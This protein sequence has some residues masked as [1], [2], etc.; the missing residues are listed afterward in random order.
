MNLLTLILFLLLTTLTQTLTPPENT[1]LPLHPLHP[2]LRRT[3][4]PELDIPSP[5]TPNTPD[6]DDTLWHRAHCRGTL[7]LHAMPLSESA[8]STLLSWPYTQSPFDGDLKRELRT[9]GYTDDDALHEQSDAYCDFE[10]WHHVGRAFGEL[11]VDT[12]SKGMGGPNWCW[13]LKHEGGPSVVR[14]EGGELPEVREQRYMVGGREYKITNAYSRIAIN[15]PSGILFFLHRKSPEHAAAELWSDLPPNPADLPKLRA[16]SDLAWGLWN[17]VPGD[18]ISH[19]TMIMALGIV[20][21]DTASVIIPRA[22]EAAGKTEVEK[23]PGTDFVVGEGGGEMQEA[24]EALIGMS[25][26][27]FLLQHKRQLGGAKSIWKVKVFKGDDDFESEDPNLIF[28]V[29]SGASPSR[30]AKAGPALLMEEGLRERAGEEEDGWGEPRVLS[31]SEDGKA[32]I[33]E[34]IWMVGV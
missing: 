3:S 12:R 22:L 24:V 30:R 26:S 19:V 27:Y 23:W 25:F 21:D 5:Q 1:T 33:R 17:R 4:P 9:W 13:F 32:V 29:R 10:A 20:N 34:R 7:L 31:K 28:Y 8:S 2:L 18:D 16:S 6:P 15:R 14:G 11:G